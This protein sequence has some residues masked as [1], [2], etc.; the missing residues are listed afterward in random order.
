MHRTRH[1]SI[2]DIYF[3]F[4]IRIKDLGQPWYNGHGWSTSR[5]RWSL[6]EVPKSAGYPAM[7]GPDAA[8]E[9]PRPESEMRS[10]E[11]GAQSAWTVPKFGDPMIP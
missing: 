5:I 11:K 6:M 3:P 7:D 2:V 1:S 9:A 10:A 8:T 4:I